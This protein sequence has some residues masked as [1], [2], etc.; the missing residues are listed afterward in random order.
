[1][2]PNSNVKYYYSEDWENVVKSVP[3]GC[4]STLPCC[5]RRT[6][7]HY[8]PWENDLRTTPSSWNG[9]DEPDTC[10]TTYTQ[11][12]V[13]DKTKCIYKYDIPYR[14]TKRVP[15]LPCC[16]PSYQNHL[17]AEYTY[18]YRDLQGN[19]K[20]DEEEVTLERK[21]LDKQSVRCERK[22]K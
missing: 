5:N 21:I 15:S 18:E 10:G 7:G 3:G 14:E 9:T 17:I 6:E 11:F 13:V 8:T 2:H 16:S 12:R 19:L 20:A 1:M 4:P 22:V